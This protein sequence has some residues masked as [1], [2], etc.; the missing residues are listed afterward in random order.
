[1]SECCHRPGGLQGG[2]QGPRPL[3]QLR[4]GRLLTEGWDS[5]E[6]VRTGFKGKLVWEML[7]DVTPWG[8]AA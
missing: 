1:M 5:A 2:L 7:L 3:L 6:H 8:V 4:E